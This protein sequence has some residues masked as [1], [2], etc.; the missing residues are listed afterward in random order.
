M[1]PIARLQNSDSQQR[2]TVYTTRLV[3]YYL[4]VLEDSEHGTAKMS[5]DEQ[6]ESDKDSNATIS[7]DREETSEG[8][9]HSRELETT[10]NIRVYNSQTSLLRFV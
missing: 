7:D 8:E 1:R 9:M 10:A 6:T 3:C 4:R 5:P 2:Y